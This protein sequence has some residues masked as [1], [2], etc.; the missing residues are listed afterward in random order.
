MLLL[1]V[2]I[3]IL[4]ALLVLFGAPTR[5]TALA[6][7]T[8]T[9]IVTLIALF[10]Y[11]PAVSGFQFVSS[12]TISQSWQLHFSLGADGLSLI[13]LFLASLVLLCAVW[14]TPPRIEKSERLFYACLLL[15]AS[16]AI[17]ECHR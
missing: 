13:M 2:F 17:G 6:G 3:P 8:A 15:V 11:Q 5:L 1:I 16:G 10:L 14:F 7:S 12:W 9:T 4:T